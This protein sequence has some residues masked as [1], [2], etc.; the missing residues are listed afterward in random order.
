MGG[1][2]KLYALRGSCSLATHLLLEELGLPFELVLL[3]LGKE[4]D[5]SK[6]ASVNG[7]RQVP[8]LE[9][10]DGSILTQNLS[11]LLHLA[12]GAE[13]RALFPAPE[14]PRFP[15]AME[16]MSLL[17]TNVHTAFTPIFLPGNF[18]PDEAAVEA[19]RDTAKAR[20]ETIFGVME[21]RA[22]ATGHFLGERFSLLDLY[23]FVFFRWL[24]I[25]GIDEAAF[26]KLRRLAEQVRAR[27]ATRRAL[28]REKIRR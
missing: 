18:H 21:S 25:A 14:D 1:M 2:Y 7:M 13:E 27:D 24:R 5:R 17:A 6:L 8:V 15:K 4:E 22:P 16:W 23:H 20:I 11:I 19:I 26:P 9:L 12:R 3:D 10:P 28:D